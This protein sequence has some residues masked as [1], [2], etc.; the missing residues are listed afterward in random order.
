MDRANPEEQG[1]L[2]MFAD[3]RHCLALTELLKRV[4]YAARRDERKKLRQKKA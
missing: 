2:G 3:T 4:D 1:G